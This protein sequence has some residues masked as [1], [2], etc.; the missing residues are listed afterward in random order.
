MLHIYTSNTSVNDIPYKL[1][2]AIAD[3]SSKIM[4]PEVQ[5]N[6]SIPK[7][8][9]EILD[10]CDFCLAN[11]LCGLGDSD[12]YIVTFSRD[13]I[14]WVLNEIMQTEYGHTPKVEIL[15]ENVK[16]H[17]YS[18]NRTR[19]IIDIHQIDGTHNR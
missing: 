4:F 18:P 10:W 12:L 1:I 5:N 2:D 16:V 7:T 13:I 6:T 8:S 9:S 3:D 14:S 11:M 15:A 17:N 19:E